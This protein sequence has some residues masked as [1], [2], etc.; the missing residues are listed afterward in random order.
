MTT[1]ARTP[2]DDCQVG[3]HRMSSGPHGSVVYD[4][5]SSCE[6]TTGKECHRV[7]YGTGSWTETV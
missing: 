7:F 4:A 2:C 5:C 6:C 3:W 1:G